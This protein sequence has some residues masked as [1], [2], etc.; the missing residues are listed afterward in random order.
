MLRIGPY[1]LYSIET[2]RFR[3]DGGA[4]FGVVP[5]VVWER[6]APPDD[7]HRIRLAM[8]SLLAI[9]RAAGHSI[10]VD[11]GAG[12]KWSAEERERFAFE[13]D[14]ALFDA[15]LS[16]LGLSRERITDVLVTHLHFDHNGGLTEWA[17]EPG[18]KLQPRFPNA[19]HWIHE[20]H[21]AHAREPTEKDRA[22]FFPRDFEPI[23]QAGLF[24]LLSGDAPACPFPATRWFMS[25]GHSPYQMLPLFDDGRTRVLF[26][27]DVIPTFA[28]LPV[29]W[30]MAYDLEPLKTMA[31][32]TRVL[33]MCAAD[34]LLLASEH[35]PG[36][37]AA[38][39]NTAGKRPAVAKPVEI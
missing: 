36:V 15:R 2:G 37:A 25:H 29:P 11:T 33:Q 23:A 13:V 31:E 16:E 18:G 5:R 30:V 20:R 19:R 32:K 22:S 28:H 9:D 14:H 10:L 3:L 6:A 24:E 8:R 4:M 12:D 39:I 34:G 17:G 38:S 21:L 26:T 7:L 35:D 27:G 1:E